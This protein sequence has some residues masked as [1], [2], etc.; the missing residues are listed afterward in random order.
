MSEVL[1]CGQCWE[2]LDSAGRYAADWSE[3]EGGS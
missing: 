3:A 1:A 2:S